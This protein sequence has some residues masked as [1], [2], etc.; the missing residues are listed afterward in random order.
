MEGK[1]I[2]IPPITITFIILHLQSSWTSINSSPEVI[3]DDVNANQ[4]FQLFQSSF[5]NYVWI[6][7]SNNYHKRKLNGIIW[8]QSGFE[9]LQQ[10]RQVP[11]ND[12]ST[13][14]VQKLF[15]LEHTKKPNLEL[16][17]SSYAIKKGNGMD[18]ST[19][20][21]SRIFHHCQ[22]IQSQLS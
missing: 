7:I 13:W 12:Y 22:S 21:E 1:I 6:F 14:E 8:R 10:R 9:M 17:L 4:T 19:E 3:S 15:D 20:I 2:L 5:R 16:R 18:E 11:K